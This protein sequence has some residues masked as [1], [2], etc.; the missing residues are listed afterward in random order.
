MGSGE[1]GAPPHGVSMSGPATPVK[2]GLRPYPR[3]TRANPLDYGRKW[4]MRLVFLVGFSFLYFPLMSLIAF[5]FND[6]RMNITWQGFTLKYYEKALTN[7]GLHEALVHSLVVAG[8]NTVV[9]GI[10]GTLLGLGLYRFRFR[11]QGLFEGWC[12]LPIVIP[13]ICMGVTMLVFFARLDMPL[14]LTTITI[15]HISFSVPFVA[16]VVRARMSGFDRALEEASYDLGATRWQTFRHV[17]VPYMLPGIIA[18]CLLVFTLSLDNFVI[19]FFTSGPGST[20]FPI[21]IYSMLRFG[22]TPEVNAASTLLIV[23]TLTITC[24]ALAV[25]AR[26][27]SRRTNEH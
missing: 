12:H 5:S 18:G 24:A 11:A 8:I 16:V 23:L 1:P 21:K 25:H 13:E 22:V 17:T 20:T 9:A 26:A 6:S 14:S 4:W 15:S 19:S 3:R 7:E 2:T 10:L 27:G